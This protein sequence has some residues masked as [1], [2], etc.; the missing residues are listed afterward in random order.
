MSG[1]QWNR[2]PVTEKT[3]KAKS[4]FFEK[5]INKFVKLDWLR[6]KKENTND[7]RDISTD[8]YRYKGM[9]F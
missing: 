2:R 3:N 8:P 6:K 1:N 9:E 5:K 7:S 4:L